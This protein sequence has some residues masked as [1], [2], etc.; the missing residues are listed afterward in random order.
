VARVVG[1]GAGFLTFFLD[2][3][4]GLLPALL[5]K[6]GSGVNAGILAGVG[7]IAGHIFPPFFKFRGGKG[8]A[9]S[10]GVFIGLAPLTSGFGFLV[11]IVLFLAFRWVSLA[12]VA[13]ALAVPLF[14]FFARHSRFCEFSNGIMALAVA[15]TLAVVLRHW[16]N[17]KRLLKGREPRFSLKK[18]VEKGRGE[19]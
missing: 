1:K 15:A 8:V 19:T 5:F 14:L 2:V 17:I 10:L 11:W 18:G 9:T 16:S 3:L 6:H 12:S 7:A 13:G 4:K